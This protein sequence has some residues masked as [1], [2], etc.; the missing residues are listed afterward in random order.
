M[1][2][3]ANKKLDM[4]DRIFLRVSI[5]REPQFRALI[6]RDRSRWTFRRKR[7][8]NM[9]ALCLRSQRATEKHNESDAEI[10]AAYIRNA[11]FI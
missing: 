11:E 10:N 2:V 5:M 3:A 1:C 7:A 8:A 6:R 9:P 4:P